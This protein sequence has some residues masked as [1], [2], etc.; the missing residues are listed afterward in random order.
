MNIKVLFPHEMEVRNVGW[1]H[2]AQVQ[3]VHLENCNGA[4]DEFLFMHG[5]IVLVVRV[6][7]PVSLADVLAELNKLE[8][9]V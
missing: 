6:A 4:A 9:R 3:A 8:G 1:H 2:C 7:G 5:N